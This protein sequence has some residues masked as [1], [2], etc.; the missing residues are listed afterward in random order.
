[1]DLLISE[2]AMK[3]GRRGG[4]LIISRCTDGEVVRALPMSLLSSIIVMASS[5]LSASLAS[6]CYKNSIPITYL[7]RT[8]EL[9]AQ[10]TI[11]NVR[12]LEMKTAQYKLLEDMNKRLI[13]SRSLVQAKIGNSLRFLQRHRSINISADYLAAARRPLEETTLDELM[14]YEGYSARLY[15]NSL[16]QVIPDWCGFKKRVK[17]NPGDPVNMMLSLAY[18]LLYRTFSATILTYGLDPLAG[19]YHSP[20]NGHYALASDLMEPFRPAVVDR[21]VIR[22]LG[23]KQVKEDDFPETWNRKRLPKAVL[24]NLLKE[25]RK[26][27]SERIVFKGTTVTYLDLIH[28][29]VKEYGR[30]LIDKR[31]RYK[32]WKSS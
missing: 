32:P 1:M 7:S 31:I 20:A 21:T 12:F 19:F 6:Y 17:R 11:A 14:G 5:S 24:S 4:R 13:I 10:V 27:L 26:R 25:Y 22:C 28:A 29:Q 15:F 16:R 23:R 9:M 8:G 2:P 3:L 30:S 18:T